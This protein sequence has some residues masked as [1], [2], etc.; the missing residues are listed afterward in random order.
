MYLASYPDA[1]IRDEQMF[2]EKYRDGF[3]CVKDN[4]VLGFIA[5]EVTPFGFKLNLSGTLPREH[6]LTEISTELV[7][8]KKAK[9]LV[10]PGYYQEASQAVSWI[11]RSKFN[12]RPHTKLST[13]QRLFPDEEVQLIEPY[14][15][16]PGV[17]VYRRRKSPSSPWRTESLFGLPCAQFY[18]LQYQM[19]KNAS[20]CAEECVFSSNLL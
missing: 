13:I 1:R 6:P 10:T 17:E 12:L 18:K 11:L 16:K 7:Q 15:D 19:R 8:I 9:L 5:Y 3:V 2:F 20:T 4:L 14:V